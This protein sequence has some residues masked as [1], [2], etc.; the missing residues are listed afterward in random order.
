MEISS[1]GEALQDFFKNF[2][3]AFRGAK[4]EWMAVEAVTDVVPLAADTAG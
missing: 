2:W 4:E 3:P 1:I